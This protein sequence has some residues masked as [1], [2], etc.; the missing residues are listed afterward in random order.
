MST[1]TVLLYSV[2]MPTHLQCL[3]VPVVDDETCERAYPGM[4]SRRMMC[5]GYMD[6]GRDACNVN[7]SFL[8]FPFMFSDIEFHL[9]YWYIFNV[10][11]LAA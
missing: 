9:F 2:A 10:T 1:S 7:Y 3:D 8:V 6:G 5:A 4:I 11:P